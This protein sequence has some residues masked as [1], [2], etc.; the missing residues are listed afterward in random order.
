MRLRALQI[1]DRAV[2]IDVT[3]EEMNR[4]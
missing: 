2:H 4:F 3:A 1:D